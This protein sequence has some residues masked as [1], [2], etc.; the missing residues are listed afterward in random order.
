MKRAKIRT[1]RVRHNVIQ[2]R[3]KKVTART[4]QQLSMYLSQTRGDLEFE[5]NLDINQNGRNKL[6][7]I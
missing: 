5:H 7:A 4:Q 1:D 6:K 2:D 3:G